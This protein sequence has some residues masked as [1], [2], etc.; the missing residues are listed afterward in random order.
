MITEIHST[1]AAVPS[2]GELAERRQSS[3][4]GTTYA[5]FLARLR[6]KGFASDAEA[7]RTAVAVLCAL[8][9][10]LGNDQSFKLESQ[11]PSILVEL[12]AACPRQR[13]QPRHI[14]KREFSELVNEY[15]DGA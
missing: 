4:A 9:Q 6:T 14:G 3:R 1:A 10:R 11:L 12:L 15:L 5:I 7:E 8:E 2:S 13:L